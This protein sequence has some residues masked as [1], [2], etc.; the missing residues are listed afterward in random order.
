MG[1][2]GWK[3]PKGIWMAV[4]KAVL[5]SNEESDSKAQQIYSYVKFKNKIKLKK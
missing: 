2:K 3:G 5:I 1:S 4:E